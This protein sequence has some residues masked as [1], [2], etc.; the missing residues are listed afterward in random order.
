MI[1]KSISLYYNLNI[2]D[3]FNYCIND[4]DK[5]IR[6]IKEVVYYK[7]GEWDDDIKKDIVRLKLE[8]IPKE[9]P[10]KILNLILN[11][12]GTIINKVKIKV[13]EKTDNYIKLKIKIKPIA[14][15][16]FKINDILKL[17]SIKATISITQAEYNMAVINSTYKISIINIIDNVDFIEKYIEG[18]LNKLFIDNMKSYLIDIENNSI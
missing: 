15:I 17:T 11:E 4:N 7:Q 9:I 1:E 6:R 8:E 14:N 18:L 3:V 10:E 12:D 2:A 13:I 5:M 16:L